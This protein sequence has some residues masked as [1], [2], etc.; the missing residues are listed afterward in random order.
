MLRELAPGLHGPK[1]NSLK[2]WMVVTREIPEAILCLSTSSKTLLIGEVPKAKENSPIQKCKRMKT[3]NAS[4]IP[5]KTVL[6][7]LAVRSSR[8]RNSNGIPFFLRPGSWREKMESYSCSNRQGRQLFT[9]MVGV[10]LTLYYI[11]S[12]LYFHLF[13]CWW[14]LRHECPPTKKR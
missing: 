2:H 3:K 6:T 5:L 9:I 11:S 7:S 14:L 4:G 10:F 12:Y 8:T 1:A 13:I